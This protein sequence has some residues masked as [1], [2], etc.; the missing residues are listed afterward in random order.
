M[1]LAHLALAFLALPSLSC[2]G[3][4]LPLYEESRSEALAQPSPPGPHWEPDAVLHLTDAL[5]EDVVE[6]ALEEYG[7]LSEPVDLPALR[8][9]LTPVLH[10]DRVK[11]SSTD[12]CERCL[13]VKAHLDGDLRWKLGARKGSVD[14]SGSA[15][16]DVELVTEQDKG[17]WTVQ[18]VP[19]QIRR[20][21]VQLGKINPKLAAKAEGA[22]KDWLRERLLAKVPTYD[23]GPFG[24]EDVPLLAVKVLPAPRGVRVAMLTSAPGAT[25]VEVRDSKLS[26]GWQ[27]D[28][29]QGSL[30]GLARRASFEYGAA[31]YDIVSEPTS[32][33]MGRD[34]FTM[35]L[36]LWR[37]KG[38]GWWRDYTVQGDFDVNDK[39]RLVLEPR[40]VEEGD[41][42]EG[43]SV[44]D[45]L[46]LLAEGYILSTIEQTLAT[47]VPVQQ[48]LTLGDRDVTVRIDRVWG[49]GHTLTAKGGVE[50]ERASRSR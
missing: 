10:V 16:F 48:G 24:A 12:R 29:S 17:Q 21:E 42:S 40:S 39:G 34:H 49:A 44:V 18:I 38:K 4:V 50:I 41:K 36:R 45:P 8:A 7:T 20:A 28:I 30:L 33:T 11:I 47:S 26:E 19:K 5:L 43:A 13:A 2:V 46:A 1:R 23:L 27:L 14:A 15:V 32:L 37:P 31:S 3:S 6:V 22:V 9:S 35:G 25:P